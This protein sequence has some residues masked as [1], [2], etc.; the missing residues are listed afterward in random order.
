MDGVLR[1]FKGLR[2]YAFCLRW[3]GEE[4]AWI[5][6]STSSSCPPPP[7]SLSHC[8]PDEDP[9]I[10][11]API[12]SEPPGGLSAELGRKIDTPGLKREGGFWQIPLLFAPK[13]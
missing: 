11:T 5:V 2:L 7:P 9:S 10:H 13:Q 3:M 4:R 12:P 6:W 8:S 1:R